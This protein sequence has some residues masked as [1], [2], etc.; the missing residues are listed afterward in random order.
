MHL[1]YD[2][3]MDFAAAATSATPFMFDPVLRFTFNEKVRDEEMLV[4][5]SMIANNP[6]LYA[7]I[8]TKAWRNIENV[9]VTSLGFRP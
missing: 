2:V 9:R 1:D 3:R 6:S 7:L 4:D 5:G 8:Y